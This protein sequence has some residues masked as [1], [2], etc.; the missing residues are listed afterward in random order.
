LA[1]STFFEQVYAI[2]RLIPEGRV[3]TYGAVANALGSKGARMV[4]FA[5]NNAHAVSPKVPAHRVVN[6]KGILTGKNHFA[7]PNRMQELLKEEG[8]KVVE[9]Q[10]QDFD[11]LFWNPIDEI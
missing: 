7:T 2:C 1:D 5:M 3:T 8:I 6:R 4:G 10:I 9:D 11:Q